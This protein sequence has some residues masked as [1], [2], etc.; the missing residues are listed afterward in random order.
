MKSTVTPTTLTLVH[1]D[2]TSRSLGTLRLVNGAATYD[3]SDAGLKKALD[4]I[5]ADGPTLS[6]DMGCSTERVSPADNDYVQAI[7]ANLP[8][9]YFFRELLPKQ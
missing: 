1:L 5:F 2:D 8:R 4:K 7:E 3:T 6:V 9:H